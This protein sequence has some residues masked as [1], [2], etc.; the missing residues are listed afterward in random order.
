MRKLILLVLVALVGL[1]VASPAQANAH[2]P[3][4]PLSIALKKAFQLWGQKPCEGNYRVVLVP[5]IRHDP[6]FAGYASFDSPSG[7]GYYLD[8]ASTR[9]NCVLELRADD[10]TTESISLEWS[11]LCTT[12]LH[13][14]GHL[15]GY[16]HT[17]E[18][19]GFTNTPGSPSE[20]HEQRMVM[21]SGKGSYS[22][23]LHRCG[24]SP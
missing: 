18:V 5:I 6:K 7:P 9:T 15:L 10:W 21:R 23:D 19:P 20:T 16:I 17:D 4:T 12:V 13:E 3:R 24:W 2:H 22:D 14:W 1:S 8:P 11:Q